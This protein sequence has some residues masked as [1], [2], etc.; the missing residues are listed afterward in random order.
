MPASTALDAVERRL[1]SGDNDDD[2]TATESVRRRYDD[3]AYTITLSVECF[4]LV[5][6]TAVT[7]TAIT[8]VVIE[9]ATGAA[10]TSAYHSAVIQPPRRCAPLNN[11]SVS[12]SDELA[13]GLDD[14]QQAHSAWSAASSPHLWQRIHPDNTH[15][16]FDH[17]CPDKTAE[18]VRMERGRRRVRRRLHRAPSNHGRNEL[19]HDAR[20]SLLVSRLLIR[21]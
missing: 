6:V 18:A 5:I 15:R 19:I 16:L 13:G 21:R 12:V 11:L 20:S 14:R 17:Y 2:D 7:V 4:L 8:L 10:T 1:L 9:F 3:A